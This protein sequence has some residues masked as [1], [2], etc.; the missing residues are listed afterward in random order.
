VPLGLELTRVTD[1]AKKIADF[2]SALHHRFLFGME[3]VAWVSPEHVADVL[4]D[5]KHESRRRHRRDARR[6]EGQGAGTVNPPLR[7]PRVWFDKP[8]IPEWRTLRP[9]VQRGCAAPHPRRDDRDRPVAVRLR[10]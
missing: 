5:A 8:S 6:C 1:A 4:A 7:P 10:R 9:L 3:D 2:A